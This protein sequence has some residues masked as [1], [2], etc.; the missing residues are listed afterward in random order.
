MTTRFGLLHNSIDFGSPAPNAG[1]RL[2]V[3]GRTP[4]WS[5]PKP[6]KVL[7]QRR[8]AGVDLAERNPR[9]GPFSRAGVRGADARDLETSSYECHYNLQS[10]A[11]SR[12]SLEFIQRARLGESI[13]V[14]NLA[15]G[16]S[17]GT[18]HPT[19]T[20]GR[21]RGDRREPWMSEK[22]LHPAQG[23]TLSST[24]KTTAV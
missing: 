11:A 3:R 8:V 1:E 22:N 2:G 23:L 16:A 17:E 7:I 19:G 6:C 14:G 21:R 9:D 4:R 10:S 18:T 15:D 13:D 20:I 24:R 12:G 5:S